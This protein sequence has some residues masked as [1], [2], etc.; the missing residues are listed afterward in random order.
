MTRV[1]KTALLALLAPACSAILLAA[2][3]AAQVGPSLPPR[4]AEFLVAPNS[5]G[6]LWAWSVATADLD[7]DGDIDY[8][9]ADID[10]QLGGV[11]AYASVVLNHGDGTFSDP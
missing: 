8:V 6:G 10:E 3:S 2:S 5:G 1:E 9:T 4:K 7:L 11:P